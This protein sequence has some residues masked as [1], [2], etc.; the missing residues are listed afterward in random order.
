MYCCCCCCSDRAT[1]SD[2]DEIP[3][4]GRCEEFAEFCGILLD[5]GMGVPVVDGG[6]SWS[7]DGVD[8]A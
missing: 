1:E 2:V 7:R 5:D 4:D 6:S 8:T 3:E